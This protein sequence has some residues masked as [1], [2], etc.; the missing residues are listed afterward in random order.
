M[1][2]TACAVEV[3]DN[4]LIASI[5]SGVEVGDSKGALAGQTVTKVSGV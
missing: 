4:S 2:D 5:V 3:K 1:L